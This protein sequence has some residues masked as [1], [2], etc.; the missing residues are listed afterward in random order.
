MAN[1]KESIK[2]DFADFADKIA[3]L[4]SLKHELAS[5]DTKGFE[6]EANVIKA[7]LNNVDSISTAEK[8]IMDLEEKIKNKNPIPEKTKAKPDINI[9]VESKYNDFVT[10]LKEELDNRLKEKEEVVS[11]LKTDLKKQKQEFSRKY[12]EMNEEFHSEYSKKVKQELERTVREKFDQMLEQRLSDEKKKIINA[13]VQEYATRIHDEKKKT[14]EKLNSDYMKKQEALESNYSKKMRELE[15]NLGKRKNILE[16]DYSQKKGESEKKSA[17]KTNVL[18]SQL[19]KLEDEKKK[20]VSQAIEL[21][22]RRQNID[23]EVISKVNIEREKIEKKYSKKKKESE[24]QL[25]QGTDLV[26]T[27]LRNL[28]Q[29]RKRLK[30]EEEEFRRRKQN[31]DVEVASK[32]DQTKRKMYGILASKFKEIKNKSNEVLSQKERSLR[33]KL[34][35]EYRGKLKKEMQAKE[36]QLEKKKKQLEKHIQQQAKQLFG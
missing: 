20:L 34:E 22:N 25:A 2:K 30:E 9:L 21:Q 32:V 17:E 31:L 11:T 8:E 6:S 4:E 29:E 13:L 28:E 5:L 23:K 35:R 16:S 14:I 24:R 27:K 33:P 3:R 26:I 36:N 10:G 18:I 19:R 7:K 12:V 15:E 1:N